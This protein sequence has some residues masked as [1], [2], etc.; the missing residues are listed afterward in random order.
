MEGSDLLSEEREL[1]EPLSSTA[2]PHTANDSDLLV[3]TSYSRR[4]I[5]DRTLKG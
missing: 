4:Q 2:K 1:L 3:A 5:K